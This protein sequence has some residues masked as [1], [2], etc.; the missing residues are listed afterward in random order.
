MELINATGCGWVVLCGVGD[1]NI[2]AAKTT[3]DGKKMYELMGEL[4]HC[5]IMQLPPGAQGRGALEFWKA[6]VISTVIFSNQYSPDL[7]KKIEFLEKRTKELE[8]RYEKECKGKASSP[9]ILITG[10]PTTGVMD[11]VIRRIEEL[12]ED[13]VG[14]K[15]C[16]GPREKKDLIDESKDPITAIAEK[17]LRVNC[18]VMSLNP[19]KFEALDVQINECQVDGVIE[20]LLHA[21]HTF[22]IEADAV[23]KFVTQKKNIPY[24]AIYTDYSMAD[25]AQ[26]DTRLGAFIELL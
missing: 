15:N 19:G 6:E 8:E 2:P 26:I 21:C 18:S 17:Y 5:H 13:V 11:K 24:T 16:C 25:Q 4:K 7:E 22:A 9:R 14:F 10:C 3:C 12:G 23:Q 20:V 1:D